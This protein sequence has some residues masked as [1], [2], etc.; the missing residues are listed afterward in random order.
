MNAV[1]NDGRTALMI[2]AKHSSN[3]EVIFVLLDAGADPEIGDNGAQLA[4][5]YLQRNKAFEAFD[6]D[7][8][9]QLRNRLGGEPLNELTTLWV[10]S[11]D[12]LNIRTEN[13]LQASSLGVIPYG[14]QVG[15]LNAEYPWT[16]TK[17]SW[18][19]NRG[20]VLAAL[21]SKSEVEPLT[22]IT[23][24][25]VTEELFVGSWYTFEP[26]VLEERKFTG[27][28]AIENYTLHHFS[29]ANGNQF[30][31][32]YYE[33]GA[34]GEWTLSGNEVILSGERGYETSS[35]YTER[36][37]IDFYQ[38]REDWLVMEISTKGVDQDNR[39]VTGI[40]FILK[41]LSSRAEKKVRA[42][43]PWLF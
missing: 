43:L 14:T 25:A 40:E 19:G 35:K 28:P 27:S 13:D 11:V 21:L 37:N 15:F 29:T 1:D 17:I 4:W 7:Y 33:G 23:R 6:A 9:Y 39:E 24:R 38:I 20:W 26:F 36:W 34:S 10:M 22:A 5:N 18:D 30:G 12:G 32:G 41:P 42:Y 8:Y 16:R 2:A 3:P 31:I